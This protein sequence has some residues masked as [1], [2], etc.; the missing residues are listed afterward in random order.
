MDFEDYIIDVEGYHGTGMDSHEG[1]SETVGY[2]HKIK[3][4]ETLGDFVNFG[5]DE[6]RD[7]LKKD[8]MAATNIAMKSTNNKYGKGTWSN[9]D[10]NRKSILVDFAY[11][12]GKTPWMFEPDTYGPKSE[13][14]DAVV[15]GSYEDMMETDS[16]G[17][18]KGTRH[19][20]GTDKVL[21]RNQ[22]L[23]D[24]YIKPNIKPKD[25]E[26]ASG[27]GLKKIKTENKIFNL[28]EEKPLF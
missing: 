22:T 17:L 5:K 11:N 13:F 25:T 9:L 15:Q 24:T 18:W 10:E 16:T 19:I 27:D 2:G 8:I 23:I 20:S 4:E 7:L 28:L 12:S 6:F 26:P 1:G 14:G 3:G 21:G